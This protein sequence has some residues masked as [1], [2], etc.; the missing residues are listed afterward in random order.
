MRSVAKSRNIGSSVANLLE[1]AKD[2]RCLATLNF[3]MPVVSLQLLCFRGGLEVSI[4]G[5]KNSP[6]CLSFRCCTD[7]GYVF[8]WCNYSWW[9]IWIFGLD[10]SKRFEDWSQEE[11]TSPHPIVLRQFSSLDSWSHKSA[12]PSSLETIRVV[13][14]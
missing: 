13:S 10:L 3:L 6:V 7:C 11:D 12:N 5:L 9:N 2:D 8:N 4:R 1:T 14:K